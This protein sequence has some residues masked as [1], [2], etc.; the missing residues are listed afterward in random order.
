MTAA[1]AH[2]AYRPFK[3]AEGKGTLG[4][5]FFLLA[6][7]IVGFIGVSVGPAYYAGKSLET[8]VKTEA[9]RAGAH[10]YDDETIMRNILDL[11]RRNE[12]RITRENVKIDRFAG[13]IFITIEYSVPVDLLVTEK[14]LD[15]KFKAS[16]FIGR[17]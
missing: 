14:K 10:F 3:R 5:L 12:V 1:S 6:A 15:F 9:S 17:L 4:C 16:S 2:S 7:G 13:Q 11:A 8:D